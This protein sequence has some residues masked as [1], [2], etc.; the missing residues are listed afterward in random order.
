MPCSRFEMISFNHA[1]ERQTVWFDYLTI[2]S[3]RNDN[4]LWI[5]HSSLLTTHIT[6]GRFSKV[7]CRSTVVSFKPSLS[8]RQQ[9]HCVFHRLLHVTYD[10]SGKRSGGRLCVSIPCVLF[11]ALSET[12]YWKLIY[13]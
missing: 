1:I 5:K 12:A 7:L 13:K 9:P 10:K 3:F 6:L 8:K 2:I 11:M 4:L